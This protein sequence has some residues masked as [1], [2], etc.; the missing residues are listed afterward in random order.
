LSKSGGSVRPLAMG[1]AQPTPKAAAAVA[2]L[3]PT[4][5]HRQRRRNV[6]RVTPR[7][8]IMI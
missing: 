2:T 5:L 6:L 3:A 4:S 1:H 7:P 8:S